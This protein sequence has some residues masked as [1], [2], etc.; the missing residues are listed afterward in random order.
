MACRMILVHIPNR[1]PGVT[2]VARLRPVGN[3]NIPADG[4]AFYKT[5]ITDTVRF[6]GVPDNYY[7][8]G[9]SMLNSVGAETAIEWQPVASYDIGVPVLSVGSIIATGF[10]VTFTAVAG[11]TGYEYSIDYG[12][13]QSLGAPAP[14][15][16][17]GLTAGKVAVIS[18]RAVV[19]GRRGYKV[20]VSALTTP[21]DGSP[22]YY[23]QRVRTMMN[24][25]VVAYSINRLV[26]ANALKASGQIYTLT[27]GFTIGS[28]TVGGGDTYATVAAA[29]T[30][31]IELV[32]Q[33]NEASYSYVDFRDYSSAGKPSSDPLMFSVS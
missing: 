24:G 2:Y 16:V 11:A 27:N 21:A 1:I 17:T 26:I 14:I 13:W 10:Q 23:M 8:V 4:S 30:E 5:T 3:Q 31:K 20:D 28:K 32:S 22:I 7:E 25:G 12:P 33:I 15:A 18:V 19:A 29:L 9:L 6:E